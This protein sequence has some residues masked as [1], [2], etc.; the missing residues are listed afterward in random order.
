MTKQS[1]NKHDLEILNTKS[2]YKSKMISVINFGTF[3]E[4]KKPQT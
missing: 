1:A 4:F 3:K 2:I